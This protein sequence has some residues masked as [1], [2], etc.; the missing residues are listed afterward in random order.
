MIGDN[1]DTD[2]RGAQAAGMTFAHVND[3]IARH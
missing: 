2:G 1:P 3:W